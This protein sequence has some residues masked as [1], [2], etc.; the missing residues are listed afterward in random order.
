MEFT[1]EPLNLLHDYNAYEVILMQQPLTRNC[2]KL[3]RKNVLYNTFE[4]QMKKKI[5]DTKKYQ[6]FF[7]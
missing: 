2:T 4:T 5:D 1:I 6:N 7:F 3:S